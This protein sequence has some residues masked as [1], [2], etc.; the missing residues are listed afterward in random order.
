MVCDE[1]KFPNGISF[2][3]KFWFPLDHNDTPIIINTDGDEDYRD[4]WLQQVTE[5]HYLNIIY[6]SASK[7]PLAEIGEYTSRTIIQDIRK[8]TFINTN[9]EQYTEIHRKILPCE[10]HFWKGY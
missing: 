2:L 10:E 6:K 4:F 8:R 9:N 5:N 7:H 3:R 1:E